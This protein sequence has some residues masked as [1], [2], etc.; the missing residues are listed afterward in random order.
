MP[1]PPTTHAYCEGCWHN[2]PPR[3][4]VRST[5]RGAWAEDG[6]TTCCRCGS[7]TTAAVWFK[8]RAKG[9]GLSCDGVFGLTHNQVQTRKEGASMAGPLV[10]G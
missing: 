7:R 3:S 6:A 10:G 8:G 2:M 5:L 1:R 9:P 4:A